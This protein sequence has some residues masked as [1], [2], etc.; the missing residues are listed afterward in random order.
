MSM[1]GLTFVRVFVDS[2]LTVETTPRKV[3]LFDGP[4]QSGSA[5]EITPDKS[6][7][8]QVFLVVGDIRGDE[9]YSAEI[10]GHFVPR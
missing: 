2:W 7:D 10:F 8:G 9:I 5:M 4:I 1:A 6:E 3:T